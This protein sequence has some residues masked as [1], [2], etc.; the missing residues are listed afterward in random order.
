V[1]QENISDSPRPN[2][3]KRAVVR[4]IPRRLTPGIIDKN[5]DNPMRNAFF[6][7]TKLFDLLAFQRSATINKKPKIIE[8]MAII[9]HICG[10]FT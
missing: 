3:K 8:F 6:S 1:R 4:Q 9:L 10:I 7:V 5:C 2:D